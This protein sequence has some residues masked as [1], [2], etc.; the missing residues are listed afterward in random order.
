[1]ANQ[2]QGQQRYVVSGSLGHGEHSHA[3]NSVYQDGEVFENETA[4]EAEIAQLVSQ[5]TLVIPQRH[6]QMAKAF[7]I[8]GSHDVE[9]VLQRLRGERD[10]Y[11]QSARRILEEM[12]DPR[13]RA[14]REGT[15]N[16]AELQVKLRGEYDSY[17]QA[18]AKYA[19]QIAEIEAAGQP[20]QT[21][22][23]ADGE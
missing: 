16:I 15:N 21:E 3:N 6:A 14:Q 18:A 2:Q 23:V 11:L 10:G 8:G 4:S 13:G 22:P 20:E 7:I 19:E 9:A 1:M 12:R 17:L 5:G